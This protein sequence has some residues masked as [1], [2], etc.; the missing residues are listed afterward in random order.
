MTLD[1]RKQCAVCA[2]RGTCAK[3]QVAE[4]STL[5]C[6]DFTRDVALGDGEAAPASAERHK[7]IDDVFGTPKR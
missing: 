3:S 6:A 1:A 7:R 4:E 5:H 2:W